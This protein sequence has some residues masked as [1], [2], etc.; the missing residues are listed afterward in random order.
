[1]KKPIN[2]LN[3]K[4]GSDKTLTN[5]FFSFKGGFSM[6]FL[7]NRFIYIIIILTFF[8]NIFAQTKPFVDPVD[9]NFPDECTVVTVG[10]QASADGSVINSHTCDGHRYRTWLDIQP[11]KDHEP[12]SH[13]EILKRVNYDKDAMP[14]LRHVPIGEIPE[15]ESWLLENLPLVVGDRYNLIKA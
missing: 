10:K 3:W 11:A 2:Q 13:K 5:H 12:G 15:V 1:M 9:T 6:S 7:M 8:Q 14:S 4:T